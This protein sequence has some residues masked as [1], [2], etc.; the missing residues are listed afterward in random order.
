[1]V[2]SQAEG[3]AEL[4]YTVQYGVRESLAEHPRWLSR[5]RRWRQRCSSFR[6]RQPFRFTMALIQIGAKG[7]VQ[8]LETG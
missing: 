2:S 5:T 6:A 4:S 8:P 7:D 3:L 1:M